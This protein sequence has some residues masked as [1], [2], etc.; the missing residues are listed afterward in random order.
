MYRLRKRKRTFN[1]VDIFIWKCEC[2]LI[3]RSENTY[4]HDFVPVSLDVGPKD[5]KKSIDIEVL[6]IF[7][8][9]RFNRCDRSKSVDVVMTDIR[10]FCTVHLKRKTITHKFIV[11]SDFSSIERL[12]L[13]LNI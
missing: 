7:Y 5:G 2:A 1:Q 6:K 9:Q 4:P 13:E 8:R 11:F 12:N 3:V 10:V